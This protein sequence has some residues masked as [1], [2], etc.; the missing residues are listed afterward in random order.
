MSVIKNKK[1]TKKGTIDK[2]ESASVLKIAEI[3]KHWNEIKIKALQS[4]SF[5]NLLRNSINK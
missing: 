1:K 3:K 4:S 2:Q 5:L